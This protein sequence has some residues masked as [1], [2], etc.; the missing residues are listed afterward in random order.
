MSLFKKKKLKN[1]ESTIAKFTLSFPEI[2]PRGSERFPNQNNLPI[3]IDRQKITTNT[4]PRVVS[5]I[6]IDY[7]SDLKS[8]DNG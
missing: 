6:K 2:C 5:L 8:S 1:P 3:K 7:F 4:I